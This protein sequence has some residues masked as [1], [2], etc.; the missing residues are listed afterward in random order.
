VWEPPP[1]NATRLLFMEQVLLPKVEYEQLSNSAQ[2]RGLVFEQIT[3]MD[4]SLALGECFE[5][6]VEVKGETGHNLFKESERLIQVGGS[7]VPIEFLIR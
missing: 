2:L 6:E 5:L 7:V 3:K 4:L 1:S